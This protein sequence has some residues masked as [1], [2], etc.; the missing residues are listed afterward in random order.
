MEALKQLC[1]FCHTYLCEA[2]F[3]AITTIEKKQKL[4]E[5][6]GYVDKGCIG[7]YGATL[8]GGGERNATTVESINFENCVSCFYFVR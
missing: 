7:Q 1:H 3:S 8:R 6:S 5:D 4:F 2:G